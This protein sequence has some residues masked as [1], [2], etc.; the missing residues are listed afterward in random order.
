MVEL[1]PERSYT[2]DHVSDFTQAFNFY[3]LYLDK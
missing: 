1:D 3:T 2:A